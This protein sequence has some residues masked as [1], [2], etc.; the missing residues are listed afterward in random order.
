MLILKAT[1]DKGPLIVVGL[2]ARNIEL[3]KNGRQIDKDLAQF[4]IEGRLVI[5]AGDS[6]ESMMA[7]LQE[8]GLLPAS[9]A[10]GTLS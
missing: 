7:D 6:E 8:G 10:T 2:S 5:F 3:L 4:G 1:T 9:A